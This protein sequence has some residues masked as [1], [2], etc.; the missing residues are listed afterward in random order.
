[1]ISSCWQLVV[2]IS[3]ALVPKSSCSSLWHRQELL[4]PFQMIAQESAGGKLFD[5][6]LIMLQVRLEGEVMQGVKSLMTRTNSTMFMTLL[7]AFKLLLARY[8]GG[9]EDLCVGAPYAGRN[10]AEAESLIGAFLA[11]VAIRT[12]L[13][14]NPT[15]QQLTERVRAVSPAALSM[16]AS[17]RWRL[18][19]IWLL[20][21]DLHYLSGALPSAPTSPANPPSRNSPSVSV[22]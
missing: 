11:A 22:W 4:L 10:R 7:A 6:L 21:S 15:F 9:S 1:M 20:K 3:H 17:S 19:E 14:G 16:H 8:C 2:I 13:S 18:P 5:I 12:D